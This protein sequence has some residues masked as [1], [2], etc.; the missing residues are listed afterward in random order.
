MP[1]L[2]D[3]YKLA[4]L[5]T[6]MTTI[7]S[8]VDEKVKEYI[9]KHINKDNNLYIMSSKVGSAGSELHIRQIMASVGPQFIWGERVSNGFTER[10]L[11]HYPR[12]DLS[13][14]AKGF[15]RHSFIEG[16]DPSETFFVAMSGRTGTI[17]T[18][19]KTAESGYIS[20]KLIKASEELKVNYDFTIRNSSNNIIQFC[21]G[22]DNM[23]PSKLEKISKIELIEFNNKKMLDVYQFDNETDMHGA[24]NIGHTPRIM[25]LLTEYL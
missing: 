22:D 11:P 1:D 8:K 7:L 20:R 17:S 10:T 2:D 18:A 3:K 13:P 24:A 23:D 5:E 19:I 21:Y 15:V 25:L 12:N 14:E 6:D 9:N 4:Q 16:T